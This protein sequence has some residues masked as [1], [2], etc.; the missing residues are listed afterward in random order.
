ML[1]IIDSLNGKLY[2]AAVHD[3]TNKM[4]CAL[5]INQI[6]SAAPRVIQLIFMLKATA[7]H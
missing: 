5:D 6:R 2:K 4:I 3:K 1:P 7:E